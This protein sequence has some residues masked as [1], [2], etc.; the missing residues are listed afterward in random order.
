MSAVGYDLRFAI[1]TIW[2]VALASLILGA[3]LPVLFATGIR[4]LAWGA[5][6]DRDLRD[7]GLRHRVW[8]RVHHRDRQGWQLRHHLQAPVPGDL[9][10]GELADG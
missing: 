9:Q 6:G 4:S 5:A 8:H 3:G 2:K 7:R 10:E 1:E